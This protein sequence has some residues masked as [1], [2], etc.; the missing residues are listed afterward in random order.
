[1]HTSFAITTRGLN[2]DLPPMYRFGRA[3]DASLIET[4]RVAE[5]IEEA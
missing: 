5:E 1:M 2:R 3:K 4:S